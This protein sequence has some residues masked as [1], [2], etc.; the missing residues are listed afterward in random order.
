M[1]VDAELESTVRNLRSKEQ[2]LRFDSVVIGRGAST[3]DPNWFESWAEFARADRIV[4]NAGGRSNRVGLAYSNQVN[5]REDYAQDIYQSGM[6][7]FSPIGD[8]RFS[9]NALDA[10]FFP[11]YFT[12]ELP[13][14][15]S[16][17]VVM[18]DTDTVAIVPAI[19]WPAGV[20]TTG[21]KAD[22]SSSDTTMPGQT[23]TADVRNTWSWPEPIKI[24]A[25]GQF[26]VEMR[27]DAP[28]RECLSHFP[29][30]P[31]DITLQPGTFGADGTPSLPPVQCRNWFF[32]RC[33]HRGPRYVQL[34]GA[35]SS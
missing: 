27:V 26:F 15:S 2:W 24:P 34:R 17:R 16:L 30:A 6:E 20:G 31:A 18:A 28:I 23:G 19:H 1:T 32:I 12:R 22:D 11:F 14:R 33:W 29:N 10:N 4:F 5:S 13:N 8:L 25:K 35:R 7:F 9:Q 21:Q 3:V